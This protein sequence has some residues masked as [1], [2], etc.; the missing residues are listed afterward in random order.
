MDFYQKCR[1]HMRMKQLRKDMKE[2]FAELRE[3]WKD[4]MLLWFLCGL[5]LVGLFTVGPLGQ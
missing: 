3:N 2:N 5:Y 1:E 4:Y